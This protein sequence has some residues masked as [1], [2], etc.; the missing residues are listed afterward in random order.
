[1]I[2]IARYLLSELVASY[3]FSRQVKW[4]ILGVLKTDTSLVGGETLLAWWDRWRQR[5]QEDKQK[6]A[7]TLFALVAWEIW[8]ERN[9]RC[10]QSAPSTIS[11]L[12][13]T[14]KLIVDFWIEAGA[15][16]LGCLIR[17]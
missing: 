2:F 17:K 4:T 8:K 12:L 9:V 15:W 10:F 6:G 3:S 13:S 16:N 1:M 5:W 11:Q 14:I 7:D